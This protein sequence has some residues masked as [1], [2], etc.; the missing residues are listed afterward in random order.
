MLSLQPLGNFTGVAEDQRTSEQ[1]NKDY[2]V[3]EILGMGPGET[4][5]W[6][7]IT[8]SDIP[9]ITIRNQNGS[10]MCGSFAGVVALGMNNR[11]SPDKTNGSGIWVDLD[12]RFIYNLR[13]NRT[14]GMAF[15]DLLNILCKDGAP[16]DPNLDGD[17]LSESQANNYSYNI[18]TIKEAEFYRGK[19]YV[20]MA[21][22]DFTTTAAAIDA[23]YTPII[24]LRCNSKEY[25]IK[26][27]VLS[28]SLPHDINHYLPLIKA[29]NL[30]GENILVAHESWGAYTKGGRRFITKEFFDKRVE[31]VAYVIDWV[32]SSTPQYSFENKMTFG[33]KDNHD[34]SALQDVLKYE[35][36]L[37][38]NIP[39]TGNYLNLTAQAVM[40]LQL[41]N[42][43]SDPDSIRKLEG[44]VVGP[45]TLKYLQKYK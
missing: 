11:N 16:K 17:N 40:Q 2:H 32:K 22:K 10:G 31:A 3:E 24:L 26:P 25:E 37:D 27:K 30:D 38:K 8:L 43:I 44:K 19:T 18:E 6:K 12:P 5:V 36:C 23:G 45:L 15:N 41:K 20:Y 13:S 21:N 28:D 35:G 4:Y 34:V 33:M 39:S 7:N 9:D 42:Q 29:G 1:K 14:P